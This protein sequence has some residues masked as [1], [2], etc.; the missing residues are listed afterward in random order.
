MKRTDKLILCMI[1]IGIMA[2]PLQA[3]KVYSLDAAQ[4]HSKTT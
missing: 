2:V 1:L 3:Q 4:W